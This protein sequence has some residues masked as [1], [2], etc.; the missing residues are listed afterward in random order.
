MWLKSY[1]D[2]PEDQ[3]VIQNQVESSHGIIGCEMHEVFGWG[4]TLHIPVGKFSRRVRARVSQEKGKNSEV[5][6]Q[7][8]E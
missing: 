4:N 2:Y 8:P 7:N 3:S 1:K 5:G 6:S